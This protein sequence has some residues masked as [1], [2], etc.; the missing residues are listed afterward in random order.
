V[1]E[2]KPAAA[3]QKEPGF[4]EKLGPGLITG[5]ADDDPS[6]IATYSQGGAQFGYQVAWTLLFTYPLMVG[7]QLASARIG[8]VTG[9]GLAEN[10][11]RLCPGWLVTVLVALLAVANI[12]NIGADLNAMGDAA[13][14]VLG[15]GE[16]WYAAGFGIVS[17]VLQVLMPYERYVRILKWLTLTLLA[18]VGVAFV[19]HI[20]WRA[21]L[22]ASVWPHITWSK[23]Y[24]TTIV[25]I[26]GTTISPYLFFWQA[27]QEVE[28]IKRV[29]ADKPLRMAP[30]QIGA[31]Y[32][33]IKFDTLI[34]MGFSNLIAF[35]MIVAS[36]ATLHAGGI[37][38]ITTTAQAAK[39]LEPIAGSFATLLFA[40]GIIGTGLLAIPVLAGSAAYAVA[41]LLRIRR[42]LDLKF[43]KARSFYAILGV[44]VLTGLAISLADLDPIKALYWSAV[45]NAV[46]S[47]PI[48]VAVMVTACS[49]KVMKDL[50]LTIKWRVLG[51]AATG[52]MALA[53]GVMFWAM[54]TG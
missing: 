41:A 53:T 17:L 18:Y 43:S 54:M 51:W 38:N 30:A 22:T 24:A 28:E 47:V 16:A 29:A 1:P 2:Q 15:G 23:E 9:K 25:A 49:R 48:M 10:F 35:F 4:L 27:E 52:A 5:A 44:A 7:I 31:Q 36:A 32:R 40:L 34:G 45:I 37:T 8:R 50:V 3:A 21:A 11:R 12:I 19:A 42:G 33:R 6:G 39:A 20:D 13:A 46:I 14:L 26:L